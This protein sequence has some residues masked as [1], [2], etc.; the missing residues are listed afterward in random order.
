MEGDVV[1]FLFNQNETHLGMI[2]RVLKKKIIEFKAVMD[3]STT[4]F[5]K[6]C[7]QLRLAYR[8]ADS[9]TFQEKLVTAL[10]A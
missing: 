4:L 10:R 3:G 9:G 2:T 6:H 1:A 7:S 5:K 8:P